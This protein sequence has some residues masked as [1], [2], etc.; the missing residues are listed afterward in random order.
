MYVQWVENLII[1]PIYS[2]C[3]RWHS[4]GQRFDPAYLHQQKAL[5]TTVFGAFFFYF[6]NILP[7]FVLLSFLVVPHLYHICTQN[8]LKYEIKL[9]LYGDYR[10][11]LRRLAVSS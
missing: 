1:L 8:V 9:R 10:A 4:R 2:I 11:A 6:P 5:K 3:Y 7:C